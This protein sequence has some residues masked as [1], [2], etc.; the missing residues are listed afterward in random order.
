MRKKLVA[1]SFEAVAREWL[2]KNKSVWVETH[3]VTIIRRLEMNIFPFLGDRPISE[4]TA[5]ELLD[6]LRKIEQLGRV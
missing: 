3:A 4:I 1:D 5:P 6:V 2:I